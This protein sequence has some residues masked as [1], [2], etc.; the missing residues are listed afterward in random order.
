MS[1]NILILIPADPQYIPEIA[2][3][4]QALD[5]FRLA[6]PRADEVTMSSTT[7]VKFIDAG[8]NLERVIC[9]ICGMELET[10]WWIQAVD[11]AY[12]ETRFRDLLVTLPCCNS[13]SSLNDLHYDW[14]VGFACFR[15]AARN[16]NTDITDGILRFLESLI[17]IRLRKIWAHY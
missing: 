2:I 10:N 4:G 3:Q 16:P 11:V 5:V 15:L 7:D 1:D 13:L 14:P 8:G 6:V 17:G 9:P 12:E